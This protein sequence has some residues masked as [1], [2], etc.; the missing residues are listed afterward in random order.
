MFA[1]GFSVKRHISKIFFEEKYFEIVA[2][3]GKFIEG[4]KT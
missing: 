2:E 4:Q 1:E 3:N